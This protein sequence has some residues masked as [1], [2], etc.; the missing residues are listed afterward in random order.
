MDDPREYYLA[1]SPITDPGRH[2]DL[3]ADLPDDIPSLCRV[4]QGLILHI[5]WAERYGVDLSE[6]RREE[7]QL[8]HIAPRLARIL[9]LDDRPLTATRE[10]EKRAVGNCRDF[11]T[12]LCAI[13]RHRGLP[14]RARCGFGTYFTPDRY[15][16]HWVCEYWHADEKRWVMV[17]P[18][19]DDLQ[20]DTLGIDFDPC[21]MSAGRFLNGGSAWQLCR[22][23]RA[24]P[25][26]FGIFDMHGLWFVR[27]DLVRDLASLNRME[28]LPWDGWG[29]MEKEPDDFSGEDMTLL[30]RVAELTAAGD[31][32]AELRALY[33]EE[34]LLKVPPV[35]RSYYGEGFCREVDLDV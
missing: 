6:E 18:Q 9:E 11:A 24:D 4:V 28:L 22:S 17:D 19:L 33:E 27:G 5:F 1:Q 30:D 31:R 16:D 26:H 21:A 3:F 34:E 25:D 29:L 14:A 2:G 7:V 32:F 35:I 10:P 8:R 15:E 13:L 12:L 23:G 20:R